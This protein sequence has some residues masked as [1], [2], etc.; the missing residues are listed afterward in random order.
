MLLFLKAVFKMLRN[1]GNQQDLVIFLDC[2]NKTVI[3][4]AKPLNRLN[5]SLSSHKTH[6]RGIIIVK[7]II[8]FSSNL[9]AYFSNVFPAT[10]RW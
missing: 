1:M 2:F 9:A 8:C 3:L 4:L 7:Y 10:L 6:T 5:S